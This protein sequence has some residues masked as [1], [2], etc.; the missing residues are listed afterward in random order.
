MLSGACASSAVQGDARKSG[1]NPPRGYLRWWEAQHAVQLC[2]GDAGAEECDPVAAWSTV[3]DGE[4]SAWRSQCADIFFN[5]LRSQKELLD[6]PREEA[7]RWSGMWRAAARL[8]GQTD[9]PDE[10]ERYEALLRRV[11][12]DDRMS[13]QLIA[14]YFGYQAPAFEV[15][16]DRLEDALK[17]TPL[18]LAS[19]DSLWRP[20]LSALSWSKLEW[21]KHNQPTIAQAA[22]A[23]IEVEQAGAFR[24]LGVGSQPLYHR[25]A[26]QQYVF[27]RDGGAK[28]PYLLPVSAHDGRPDYNAI[29]E[30]SDPLLREDGDFM[31]CDGVPLRQFAL[32][33]SPAANHSP[34]NETLL[35]VHEGVRLKRIDDFIEAH[36]SE[37]T[38][39]AK[40]LRELAEG[41][42]CHYASHFLG[43]YGLQLDDVKVEMTTTELITKHRA[44]KVPMARLIA[45]S[46][47]LKLGPFPTLLV[48]LKSDRA[49]SESVFA[50][51]T[52]QGH[53]APVATSDV[54]RVTEL[55]APVAWRF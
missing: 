33:M 31:R 34:S 23:A 42:A 55:L 46:R 6:L 40:Q 54:E 38:Y 36:Y 21:P 20:L 19:T 52:E 2:R 3:L 16:A 30:I 41:K 25:G 7:P 24:E 53:W 17:Q 47:V 10:L 39:R 35:F 12:A 50:K 13:V 44:A 28:H 4:S 9:A 32:L 51:M 8:F 26:E 22:Y 27:V 29:F 5:V 1:L 18:S 11:V 14:S 43:L 15:L 37:F 45:L 48:E 49:S